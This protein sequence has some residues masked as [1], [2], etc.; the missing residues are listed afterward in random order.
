MS[1]PLSP[2]DSTAISGLAERLRN[3]GLTA[4]QWRAVLGVVGLWLIIDL[5]GSLATGRL[6]ASQFVTFVW[7]GLTIGLVLGL[8]GIGL[9]LTYSILQFANFSHGDV[10]T[11]GAFSG[12]SVTYLVAGFGAFS[13]EQLALL[14]PTGQLYASDIGIRFLSDPVAVFAGLVA[15]AGLTAGMSLGFDRYVYRP[16]RNVGGLML[17]IASVGVAFIIRYTI[18]VVYTPTTRAVAVTPAPVFSIGVSDG[19]LAVAASKEAFAAGQWALTLPLGLATGTERLLNVSTHEVVLVVAAAA[20]MFGVHLLLQ[21][22]KLGKAMRAMADDVELARARGIP[23]ERV[24]RWTWIIGSATTGIAGYLI[25]L[26]RGTIGFLFGWQLLLL[27]F[28]A[29]IL[30]GIGSVYGAILGGLVIGLT[31]TVSLVW[32][33][34]ATF[35]R[36]VAF[37]IMIVVLLV[38]PKGLFGGR[39]VG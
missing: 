18:V 24:V 34:E 5:V 6:S 12:W 25:V 11:A 27:I 19:T 37:F 3:G 31:S 14:G 7:D 13:F 9:T 33:P 1:T 35:T 4:G 16:L 28:A 20:L 30:G 22:T 15:A 8:A 21:R 38:R 17:L 10:V 29:V 2:P 36:P 26:E 32:L 39:D 23:T